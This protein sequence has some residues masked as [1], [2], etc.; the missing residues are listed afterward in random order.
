MPRSI[1]R[2]LVPRRLGS[3][4]R[5]RLLLDWVQ[6][7]CAGSPGPIGEASRVPAGIGMGSRRGRTLP[8]RR[9]P[10]SL[11]Q[12][13]SRRRQKPL[14]PPPV[15]RFPPAAATSA[16]APP[17]L[18]PRWCAWPSAAAP[19]RP[20]RTPPRPRRPSLS[21]GPG[22]RIPPCP[23][24]AER[25]PGVPRPRSTTTFLPLFSPPHGFCHPR[26]SRPCRPGRRSDRFGAGS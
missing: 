21:C 24:P 6:G 15:R 5:W 9:N 25:L 17:I 14:P 23:G 4:V 26:A 12:L 13:R 7:S 3:G 16:H 10:C 20:R 1:R 22:S 2:R 11:L 18:W 19:R 8:F